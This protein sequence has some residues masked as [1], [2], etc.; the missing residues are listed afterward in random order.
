MHRNLWIATAAAAATLSI[1][2][3]AGAGEN[4]K[5]VAF[6][7]I[8]RN[9]DAMAK[10]GDSIYYFAE[11]GMQEFESAKLLKEVLESGGFTVELGGAGMPTNVWAKW[12]SGKPVIAIVTE[13]DALQEGSQTPRCLI[14]SR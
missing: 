7:V 14:T 10:I 12:G 11:L 1:A 3:P 4:P 5:D 8:D 6:Q 13:V 9:T 2:A